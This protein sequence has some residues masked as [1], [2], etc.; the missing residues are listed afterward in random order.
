MYSYVSGY[1]F[2]GA[3]KFWWLFIAAGVFSFSSPYIM[4]SDISSGRA[5]VVA[6]GAILIGVSLKLNNFGLQ[7]DIKKDRIRD[8]VSI[9]GIKKGQWQR[10]PDVQKITL[11][12]K[13]VSSWNTANGISPTFKSTNSI[14]TIAIFSDRSAPDY[15]IQIEN[16]RH[17]SKQ[18]EKLSA[19]FGV[20]LELL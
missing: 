5:A 6:A 13:N 20:K 15:L 12:S 2:G 17:A 14:F 11:T 16:E 3:A 9:M 8:Y 4:D 7:V 19:F 1:F 18:A 10:I